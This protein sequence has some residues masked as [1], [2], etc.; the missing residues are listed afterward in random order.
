MV[1]RFNPPTTTAS[2]HTTLHT[3]ST[4]LPVLVFHTST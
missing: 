3:M 2:E 1:A 4:V